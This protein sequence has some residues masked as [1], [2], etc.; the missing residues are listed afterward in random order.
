MTRWRRTRDH[1]TLEENLSSAAV[2][3]DGARQDAEDVANKVKAI[4]N[5]AAGQPAVK[6]NTHTNQVIAPDTSHLTD[7]AAA[8]VA[9]KVADLQ[10]RVAQVLVEGAGVDADLAGAIKTATDDGPVT[11]DARPEVQQALS[12][13]LPEDPEKFAELW[14]KLSEGQ[15]D[16]LYSQDHFIGNHPGMP[17]ADRNHYNGLHLEEL[18]D[19][20]QARVDSLQSRID[21]LARRAYMGEHDAGAAGQVA[22]LKSQLEAANNKLTEYRTVQDVVESTEGPQRYLGLIDDQ[23]HAAVSIGN[24]DAA[25]RNAI[26]VP[27]TGQDLTAFAG[28]DQ[29][30]LRMYQAALSADSRLNPSDVAVTTWMGYDRPMSLPEAAWPGRAENGGAALDAFVDGMHASHVGPPALDT[31]IGHSYGSTLV[32]GAASGGNDLAVDNV[33]GV[34]SPGMLVDH[35]SALS[36]DQ[37]A[38]VY[39]M[40]AQHDI[41]HLVSGATLGLNPTWDGF[42]A[43]ELQAAPGPATGPPILNLPSVEAHSSYWDRGNVALDNMGAIIAGQPPVQIVPPG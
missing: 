34:G 38:Q 28:S 31:V 20:A 23:G 12:G 2:G 13:P 17:F 3:M 37:G 40:R 39:A 15:R 30:S 43:T 1:D 21:E 11:H 16:W 33:I 25:S 24:P 10:K 6:V 4:L 35:A 5:D 19:Q 18:T 26:L 32:G 9:A 42:G 8:Q 22:A 14:D 29:K 27:G 7:E 36:L 41:I